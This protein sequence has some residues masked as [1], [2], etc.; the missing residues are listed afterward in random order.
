[1]S[2]ALRPD[3]L[4]TNEELAVLRRVAIGQAP[5][6]LIIR[7]GS[8]LSVHTGEFLLRDVVVSGRHIAAVTPVGHFDCE[9]VIDAA[10]KHVL[11]TFIDAHLHIEWTMLTPGELARLSVPRGTT[12]VLT[13]PDGLANVAGIDGMDFMRETGTP[14]RIFEQVSPS[15]PVNAALERGG[16]VIAEQLVLDRLD[17]ARSVSLGEGNPFDLSDV[18]TNR[19]RQ[20]MVAGK[21]I[22]GHSARQS[23]EGLWGYLAAGVG[24]DHNA[25]TIDEV[26]ERVRLGAMITLMSGSMNDNTVEVFA[27]LDRVGPALDHMSFCADDKH[28]LDIATEGHIDHHVR[29]AIA[30]GIPAAQAY[31]MAS[32][33]PALYYRLDHLMGSVTPGRLADLQII[34]DLAGVRAERVIVGGELVAVDGVPYFDNTDDVP[35]WLTATMHVPEEFPASLLAVPAPGETATVQAMEMYDGYFKRAFHV[36]LPVVGGAVTS[37]VERDV[38]KIAV[39]DRHYG[40]GQCGVGFVRGFQLARGA[41]AVTINCTN[42]NIVAVGTNDDDIAV[43]VGAL[44]D[45]GGGFVVV[46]GGEVV[47]RVHLPVGGMMSAAPWETTAAQLS[48]ANDVAF[49]LGCRIRSPFMV[50]SFVG[51]GVVP[52]LGLTE[53]GLIDATSQSFIDLVLTSGPDGIACRCPNHDYPVHSIMEDHS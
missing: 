37:D 22:T 7:G 26:L 14:F 12:T 9:T 20:A 52:D 50:L 15:T 48:T 27:D 31:R 2:T 10:G 32:W 41:L 40:D 38:L 49:E 5:A 39:V 6:D 28:V 8:V 35:E 36:A 21:R 13:D 19:F 42:A 47:A 1:M 34:D 29:Q 44:R 18:A 43:A 45:Q 11:P 53:L 46:D 30:A 51:L 33:Q 23:G 16:A 17:D 24:D 25:A 4:P 3:L